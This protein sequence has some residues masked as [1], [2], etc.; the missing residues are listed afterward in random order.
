MKK[1]FIVALI[2]LS[3]LQLSAHSKK[4]DPQQTLEVNIPA[5][6]DN[7]STATLKVSSRLFESRDDIASVIM[8]IPVDSVVTVLGSDSTYFHVEYDGAEGYIFKRDAL[9]NKAPTITQQMDRS[10]QEPGKTQTIQNSQQDRYSYLENK[11]GSDMAAK[12]FAG[13]IWKGMSSD[14]VNDSWG[15]ASKIN[16]IINGNVVTENWIYKNTWLYFEN[17]VLKDW[18]PVKK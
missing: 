12:L 4:V 7:T 11:Y 1:I 6:Q 9:I 5:S 10:Q 3:V 16:R 18:G 15:T 8:I 17:N 2:S 13:K 14:M